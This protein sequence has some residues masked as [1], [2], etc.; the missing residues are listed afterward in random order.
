M[1]MY[2]EMKSLKIRH[3]IDISNNYGTTDLLQLADFVAILL[4]AKKYEL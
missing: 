2:N 1:P 4:S 3:I